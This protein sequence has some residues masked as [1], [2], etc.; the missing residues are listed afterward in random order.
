MIRLIRKY[1][2]IFSNQITNE[3]LEHITFGNQESPNS[4][5]TDLYFDRE[6]D[7]VHTYFFQQLKLLAV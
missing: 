4:I 2:F 6:Q 1:I 7:G 3:T 5:T